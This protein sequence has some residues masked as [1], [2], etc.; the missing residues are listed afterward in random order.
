M[1]FKFRSFMVTLSWNDKKNVWEKNDVESAVVTEWKPLEKIEMLIVNLIFFHRI[2][3]DCILPYIVFGM[4]PFFSRHCPKGG[5]LF[6]LFFYFPL[7]LR[8]F[9]PSVC[10]LILLI[11]IFVRVEKQKK[12]SVK[13]GGKRKGVTLFCVFWPVFLCVFAFISFVSKRTSYRRMMT[14]SLL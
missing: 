1:S 10:V 6:F 13:N 12:K 5:T 14:Y 7:A 2:M 3:I 4:C 8:T 9:V 11:C